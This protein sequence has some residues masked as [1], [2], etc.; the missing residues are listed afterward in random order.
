MH[1]AR[2]SVLFLLLVCHLVLLLLTQFNLADLI[3]MQ[4][5]YLKHMLG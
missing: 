2:T 4:A 1:I 5:T 3:C